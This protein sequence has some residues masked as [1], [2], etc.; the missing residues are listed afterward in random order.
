MRGLAILAFVVTAIAAGCASTA[1][2]EQTEE[3]GD[4]ISRQDRV[5]VA[6]IASEFQRNRVME[7]SFY[8]NASWAT[9]SEIQAFLEN[10]VW[11]KPSWLATETLV[12]FEEPNS[13]PIPVSEAIV[14][15]AKAHN[16]NPL[17]LLAR[18]QVEKSLV[19]AEKRP[20]ESARSFGLGCHKASVAHPNGLDPSVAALD[21][22]LECAATTLENQ[23][24]KA[25]AGD[26]NYDI[27]K[28]AFTGDGVTIHPMNAAT[29][30][31]YAYTPIEGS[32]HQNGNWLVWNITYRFAAAIQSVR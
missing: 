28:D 15:T 11:N 4:A 18:M 8:S 13:K 10:T 20:S 12:L 19:S 24:A 21:I 3:T 25:K 16:I 22:Q 7:D 26:N 14:R 23:M 29:S 17:L 27:G 32:R 9:A 1:D 2:V 5:T 31:L 6:G 30:A